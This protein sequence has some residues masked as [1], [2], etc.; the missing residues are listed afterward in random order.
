VERTSVVNN[1]GTG[2]LP[3]RPHATPLLQE[4][5]INPHR[6]RLSAVNN[7]P[8]ISSGHKTNTN[9]IRPQG[10]PPRPVPPPLQARIGAAPPPPPPS[11]RGGPQGGGGAGLGGRR[12]HSPGA[13]GGRSRTRRQGAAGSRAGGRGPRKPRARS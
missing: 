4:K 6:A 2:I 5:T 8:P 1:G 3:P 10:A 13:G 11:G 9:K 7:G 12:A